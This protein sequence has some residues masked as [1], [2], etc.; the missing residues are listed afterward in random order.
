MVDGEAPQAPST[1]S[2]LEQRLLDSYELFMRAEP[3]VLR[4]K[5]R[6]S[7]SEEACRDIAQEAFDRVRLKIVAGD[8]TSVAKLPA[9]LRRASRNLAHDVLRREIRS[10]VLFDSDLVGS[11]P[12][13]RSGDDF[14]PLE[15]LVVPA[16]DAMPRSRRRKVVQFQS[17][18]LPDEEI[19]DLLG[20]PKDRLHKDRH[21]AVG[22]LRNRLGEH[23]RNGHHKNTRRVKKDG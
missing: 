15:E 22:E 13:P 20:I 18:G 9:Y 21:A 1:S 8:L 11:V 19:A 14:D 16:I 3:R 23:I 7:L 4:Q 10:A 17:Q 5:F 6:R 12:Q 2:E